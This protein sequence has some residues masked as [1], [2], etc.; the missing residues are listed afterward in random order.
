[1]VGIGAGVLVVV[2]LLVVFLG[3]K[4]NLNWDESYKYN[5]EQP[6][7]NFLIHSLLEARAEHDTFVTIKKSVAKELSPSSIEGTASY[8]FISNRMMHTHDDIDSLLRFAEMGHDVFISASYF[9]NEFAEALGILGCMDTAYY[10]WSYDEDADSSY[11]IYNYSMMNLTGSFRDST[12]SLN[13]M[14]PTLIFK[15]RLKYVYRVDYKPEVYTWR[16]F[17]TNRWCGD[18]EYVAK[19][20]SNYTKINFIKVNYGDGSFYLHTTPL[21]FTNLFMVEEDKLAYAQSVFSHL[22]D[23]AIYWDEGSRYYHS[24][25]KSTYKSKPFGRSE[26][27]YILSQPASKWAF[28]TLLAGILLYIVFYMK[29]RQR[30]I[31]VIEPYPNT[32]VE[33]VQTVGGLYFMKKDHRKLAEQKFK[34]FLSFVRNRYRLSTQNLDAKLIKQ[35]ASTSKVAEDKVQAI[36]ELYGSI[37]EKSAMSEAQLITFNKNL[38]YFYQNCK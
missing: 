31:P 11:K 4:E 17:D 21:A 14:H 28:Y 38:E 22:P 19:L 8:V 23:G 37:S 5:Q 6:Y 33:Y 10:D 32:S 30:I 2:L 26:L 27:K 35:L 7:D 20:G 12:A 13:L 9:E 34:L 24:D 18:D 1:M 16:Y 36:F 15:E 25:S 29:R 3:G